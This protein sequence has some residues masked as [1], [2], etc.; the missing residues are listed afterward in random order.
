MTGDVDCKTVAKINAV[1]LAECFY[2]SAE[3]I[4][5]K[6]HKIYVGGI[7][8]ALQI[9]N[10]TTLVAKIQRLHDLRKLFVMVLLLLELIDEVHA[11]YTPNYA[12]IL[13]P[14]HHDTT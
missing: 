10:V 5:R 11:K 14:N 6:P 7:H 13:P 2:R 8:S 4:P 9:L 3:F 12:T 1:T